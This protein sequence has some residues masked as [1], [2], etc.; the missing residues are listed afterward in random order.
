M[1]IEAKSQC[2]YPGDF[3]PSYPRILT[4]YSETC[5]LI[6]LASAFDLP[7]IAFSFM[8]RTVF[9]SFKAYYRASKT[10]NY[11]SAFLGVMCLL[12]YLVLPLAVFW[13]KVTAETV[14]IF[15]LIYLLYLSLGEANVLFLKTGLRLGI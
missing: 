14:L 3:Y 6:L 1:R 7:S 4:S 15:F 8:S 9:I 13:P 2:N 11:F 12:V 5:C 10:L